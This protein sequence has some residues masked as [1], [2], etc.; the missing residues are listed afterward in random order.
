MNRLDF[1]QR[2]F[3]RTSGLDIGYFDEPLWR[4]AQRWFVYG[5]AALVVGILVILPRI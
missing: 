3:D 5:A 4:K 2:D 1:E